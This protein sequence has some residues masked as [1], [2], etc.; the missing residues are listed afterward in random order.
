MKLA[1]RNQ[2]TYLEVQRTPEWYEGFRDLRK[3]SHPESKLGIPELLNQPELQILEVTKL[4]EKLKWTSYFKRAYSGKT[5]PLS[6]D[7][8]SPS[9]SRMFV[10]KSGNKEYGFMR[11]TNHSWATDKISADEFWCIAEVYVKAPYRKEK[12]ATRL[13]E[14]AI[15]NQF[16][17]CIFIDT[18]RYKTKKKYFNSLGLTNCVEFNDTLSY[19]YITGCLEG[20]YEKIIANLKTSD[21]KNTLSK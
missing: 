21:I 8:Y 19:V 4:A 20:L 13:M 1:D 18:E 16:A 15:N 17:K 14:Y 6:L 9:L 3:K 10:A 5:K 7:S 2:M 12:I 11:I